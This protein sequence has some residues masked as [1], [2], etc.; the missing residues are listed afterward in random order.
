MFA[1]Q[2]LLH[3]PP[4]TPQTHLSAFKEAQGTLGQARFI[5]S[6]IANLGQIF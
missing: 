3:S 4:H 1:R 2:A 6:L 5:S